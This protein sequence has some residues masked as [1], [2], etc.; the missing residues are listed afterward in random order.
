MITWIIAA[1]IATL[2][3]IATTFIE[4]LKEWAIQIIS[5]IFIDLVG[6]LIK[7]ISDAIVS[8]IRKGKK[9]YRQVKVPV[10]KR[11]KIMGLIPININVMETRREQINRNE[12]PKDIL[13]EVDR[14]GKKEV[15]R[16]KVR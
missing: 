3:A 6:K 9:Y 2:V 8:I 4:M 11:I 15:L 5:A 7:V 10:K 1:G 16:Q 12:I 13:Y 14:R